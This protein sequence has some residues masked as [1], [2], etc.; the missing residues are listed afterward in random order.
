MASLDSTQVLGDLV[1]TGA[2]H[3]A[4]DKLN[5]SSL[6]GSTTQP[7]HFSNGVPVA[8]GYQLLA[9]V[10]AVTTAQNGYVL[11]VVGGLLRPVQIYQYSATDLTAGTSSLATGCLYFVYE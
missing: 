4:A 11:Q 2:I 5:V 6:V 7:V 3:G 8:C 10:P 1:V 9:T